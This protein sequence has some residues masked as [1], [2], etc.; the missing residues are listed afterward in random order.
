MTSFLPE[1]TQELH[2]PRFHGD[3]PFTLHENKVMS[4]LVKHYQDGKHAGLE[5][6]THIPG[7]EKLQFELVNSVIFEISANGKITL[8]AHTCTGGQPFWL[9]VKSDWH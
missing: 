9:L 3:C 5:N 8:S 4:V 1:N 2:N 7:R 6:C